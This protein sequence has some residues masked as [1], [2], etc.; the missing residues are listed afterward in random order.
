MV[1]TNAVEA[2]AIN[3]PMTIVNEALVGCASFFINILG[4]PNDQ[5]EG[6]ER[7]DFFKQRVFD[8]AFADPNTNGDKEVERLANPPEGEEVSSAAFD[9]IQTMCV[10]VAYAVQ[11]IKAERNGQRDESW[12]HAC[13]ANYWLALLRAATVEAKFRENPAVA[14]AKKRFPS[15]EELEAL[16]LNAWKEK[17]D[18]KLSAQK[19]AETL[20]GTLVVGFDK[21][22]EIVGKEKRRLGHYD[23]HKRKK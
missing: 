17:V 9:L 18:P 22:A 19:A 3:G 11:A 5:I 1:A 15:P 23:H 10:V 14:L 20:D 12:N 16:V 4:N 13:Q 21:I 8:T 7:K 2:N 6:L